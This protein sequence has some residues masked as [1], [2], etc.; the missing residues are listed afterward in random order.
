MRGNTGE[1]ERQFIATISGGGRLKL[2]RDH[3]LVAESTEAR[4]SRP[5]AC[6]VFGATRVPAGGRSRNAGAHPEEDE[7]VPAVGE[8][9]RAGQRFAVYGRGPERRRR[10]RGLHPGWAHLQDV[11]GPWGQATADGDGEAPRRERGCH[12]WQWPEQQINKLWLVESDFEKVP[13]K[14][15]LELLRTVLL[16]A[17]G[18]HGADW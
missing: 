7:T 14:A 13:T 8:A 5:P 2:R 9:G 1:E 4:W 11:R 18:H 16:R 15:L 12:R 3:H 6:S 17:G 10:G